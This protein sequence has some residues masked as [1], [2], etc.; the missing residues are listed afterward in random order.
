MMLFGR[1]PLASLI[2]LCRVLR[3]SLGAGIMLRDV[4]R[5]QATRAPGPLR[6][7]SASICQTLEEGDSLEMALEKESRRFPPL[8][9]SLAVVG[10]QTG[11]L[12]EIFGE[13][14][15]YYQLQQKFWRRFW[16]QS[17]LPILQ[18]VAA[19]FVIGGLIFILGIIAGMNGTKPID[20]L[21]IGLTGASGAI[22][23]LVSNFGLIAVLII[24]YMYLSRFLEQKAVV[25][26]FFMILP[27]VGPLYVSLTMWRFSLALQLTLNTGMSIVRA[28]GL[29]L[30]GT[31]NAALAVR[32]RVVQDSLRSGD[33][34]TVALTKAAVFP[35]DFLHMVLVGEEGGRLP[36]IMAQQAKQYEEDAERRL[37]VVTRMGSFLVWLFVACLIITGIF[38]IVTTMILPVYGST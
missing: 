6:A 5:Q 2:Q 32:S 27:G 8:F 35:E 26:R 17:L 10:E 24:G 31:G 18:L 1:L 34:L 4:F 14:E 7:V 19:I 11:N 22:I 15:K 38:R 13:L 9:L 23:W 25:D 30:K 3:H 29:C 21:G 12:P 36:E 33:K 37:A 28:L 20:A 16:S